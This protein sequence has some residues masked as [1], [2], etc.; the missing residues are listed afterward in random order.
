MGMVDA[1]RRG[2]GLVLVVE[3]D[4]WVRDMLREVLENEGY[5]VTPAA[6]GREALALL[7]GP[8]RAQVILLDL[9]MPVMDGWQFRD[10]Q[11]SD[12]ALSHIPVVV[13]S[14]DGDLEEGVRGLA[15]AE[16]LAK[17]FTRERL[18]AAVGRFC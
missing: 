13:V 16:V 15:A 5:E 8:A 3:D 14:A 9:S 11:C 4:L 6:N 1:H 18:L 10:E 17:P 12:P 2:R 7:R